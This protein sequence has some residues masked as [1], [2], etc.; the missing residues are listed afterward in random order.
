MPKNEGDI[1]NRKS[2]RKTNYENINNSWKRII[3]NKNNAINL[4]KEIRN[5][6]EYQI[7]DNNIKNP[8]DIEVKKEIKERNEL[9][10]KKI[11]DFKNHIL[12]ISNNKIN[13]KSSRHKKI[14][15]IKNKDE[16]NDLIQDRNIKKNQ[17]INMSHDL[18]RI[19]ENDTEKYIIRRQKK[20]LK[21]E[22]N[23]Q[24][25]EGKLEQAYWKILW[26]SRKFCWW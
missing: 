22:E 15:R 7:N 25:D 3:K 4:K 1:N 5:K 10:K 8:K 21:K 6:Q 16:K 11:S 26:Q 2:Y 14:Y 12:Y 19:D 18:E 23:N 24:D 20:E 13:N 17:N 9:I